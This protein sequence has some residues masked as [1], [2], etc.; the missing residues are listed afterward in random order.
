M[1]NTEWWLSQCSASPLE[2][3]TA[4]GVLFD[5]SRYGCSPLST[6][7]HFEST[8]KQDLGCICETIS[9]TE[10]ARPTLRTPPH[11]L[12]SSD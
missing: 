4:D 2:E 1:E 12:G 9:R 5:V 11:E 8:W 6:G 10:E 3:A 7:L